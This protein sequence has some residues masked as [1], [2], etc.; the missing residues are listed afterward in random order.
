MPDQRGWSRRTF[1]HFSG[2][3]TGVALFA[4]CQAVATPGA[5]VRVDASRAN[6]DSRE[7]RFAYAGTYTRDVPGSGAS[8]IELRHPAGIA[9]FAITPGTTEFTLVETVPSEN[10]SFLAIHPT[11]R[12]LYVSN[13]IG[14]YEGKDAGS[15]EA[16]AIDEATGKLTLLNRQAVGALPVHLAVDPSGD[17]L[18][19]GNYVG[20]S[21]QL[22]PIKA[23]GSLWP[24]IDEIKQS[25]FGPHERQEAP[26]P[27]CVIFDPDGRYIAT[28][29]LGID[30][31]ETFKLDNGK[32]IKVSEA[33]VMPGSGPCQLVF[34]PGGKAIY[35][36]NELTATI[37]TFAYNA[38]SGH[39]GNELQTLHR[40]PENVSGHK[41]SAEIRMHPSGKFLYASTHRAEEQSL[42]DALLVFSIDEATGKLSAV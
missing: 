32:L 40:L 5:P 9:V 29:D 14:D 24:V 2:S 12:Y 28:A 33:V 3:V 34:H 7:A 30:K 15:V 26:H 10:P 6:S 11:Q 38:V 17:Y 37:M 36:S 41:S 42:V 22:L 25:G 8:Q 18:V 20:A 16:Y 39:I 1:L 23:D 19:V 31:V 21:Y 4:A 13:E 27:R 35:V